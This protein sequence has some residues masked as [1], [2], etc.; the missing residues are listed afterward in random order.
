MGR[1]GVSVHGPQRRGGQEETANV[2]LEMVAVR[3]PR[4]PARSQ[5]RGQDKAHKRLRE[6][7]EAQALKKAAK[8]LEK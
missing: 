2:L 8:K 1:C 7:K 4:G 6:V 5:I 3:C